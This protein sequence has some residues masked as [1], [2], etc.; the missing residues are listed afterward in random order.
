MQEFVFHALVGR[1][2]LIGA[3]RVLLRWEWEGVWGQSKHLLQHKCPGM[4]TCLLR[5][6]SFP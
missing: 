3:Q 4:F 2:E 1:V 5:T 6:R